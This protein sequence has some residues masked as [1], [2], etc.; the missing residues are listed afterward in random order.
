MKTILALLILTLGLTGV[1]GA[2]ISLGIGIRQAGVNIGLSIS[3]FPELVP[4]PS[5]PVYYDP[6]GSE[7]YFFYDGLYWVYEGDNW[8]SSTWYNGPWDLVDPIY[9]PEFVLRVP[10]RYYRR[11]P[12]LFRQWRADAAPLW[13]QRWGHDWAVRRSGWDHWDPRSAPRPAPLPTYQRDFSGSRYPR[14]PEQQ[15]SLRSDNYH[16]QPRESLGRQYWQQQGPRPAGP[17]PRM[18]APSRNPV[19][20]DSQRGRPPQT[21]PPGAESRA[22]G[23][24]GSPARG[25][26]PEERQDRRPAQRDQRDPRDK[27]ADKGPR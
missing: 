16:Y 22:N 1:A 8:Y 25:P 14:A 9:V 12:A 20:A 24:D 4:V 23:R 26:R 5:Y 21:Q 13:D 7:N 6:Q 15:R 11:P 3:S 27:D 10:V 19:P 18:P 2:Q 17:Q